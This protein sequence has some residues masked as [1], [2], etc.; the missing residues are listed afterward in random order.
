MVNEMK[1]QQTTALD[2]AA[3]APLQQHK[4][5]DGWLPLTFLTVTWICLVGI[6]MSSLWKYQSTPGKATVPLLKWPA[7]SMIQLNPKHPTLIMFAHPHCP[8]TRA[9][10]SELALLI[11]RCTGQVDAR[12][13]FS[14]P[15]KSTTRRERTALWSSVTTIPGVTVLCDHDGSEAARFQAKTSGYVLL[16]DSNGQLLFD[17]G[18]T[19]SRGHIGDNAGRTAIESILSNGVTETKQTFVFG[20]PLREQNDACDKEKQECRQQ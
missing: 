15:A 18:I 1:S 4:K 16:F 5:N 2:E 7:E 9:S 20:C 12:V 19:G 14:K 10:I 13:L 6:G 8:C 3:Q 11:E 17:G